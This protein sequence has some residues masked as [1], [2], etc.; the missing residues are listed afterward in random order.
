MEH[1]T[2]HRYKM[3]EG[4]SLVEVIVA[5]TVL[6]I[7][8]IPLLA[9]FTNASVTTSRGRNTQQANLAGETMMEELNAVEDY[10][11]LE[12]APSP[13]S[14]SVWNVTVDDSANITYVEKEIEQNGFQYYVKAK[15]DYNY[16]AKDG[17]GKDSFNAYPVPELKEV[18]S[19][20]NVVVEE[21]DQAETALSEFYYEN[22]SKDKKTILGDMKRDLCVDVE[23]KTEGGRNLYWVKTYY[24]FR[25]GGSDKVFTVRETKIEKDKL[26]NIYVFYKVLNKAIKKEKVEVRFINFVNSDDIKELSLYFVV[27]DTPATNADSTVK[28][29]ADY[30][31]DINSTSTDPDDNPTPLSPSDAGSYNNAKYFT[32]GASQA[33]T[34]S[35]TQFDSKVVKR[36]QG[37]RIA[38]ITVDV[39]EYRDGSSYPES[40]RLVRL[41]SSKGE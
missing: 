18:Y 25:Y 3:Q 32:N 15:V 31:V 29:P 1:R 8:S 30:V 35:V 19:P 7:L 24:R 40:D 37:K 5:I 14:G 26:K 16:A 17:N 9:Y 41:E 34:S 6:A 4:F 2:L 39:Y 33:A 21:T 27:Q 22:Q 11:M 20:N 23:E 13:V 38:L 12:T 10:E 36:E 28:I